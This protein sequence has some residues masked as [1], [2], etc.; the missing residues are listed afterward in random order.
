L[1]T[2]N[3]TLPPLLANCALFFITS[4]FFETMRL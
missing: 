3:T 1:V 2:K 4:R